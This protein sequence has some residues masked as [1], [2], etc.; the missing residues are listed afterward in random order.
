[1]M[2][3]AQAAKVL[4]GHIKGPTDARFMA[5]STDTRKIK[6]GDLYIALRGEKFDG[7]DFAAQAI[8]SGATAVLMNADSFEARSLILNPQ[9]SILLVADTRIALGQLAAHWRQKFNIP[10]VA[11]TGSNGKTTVK[12]M[13]A[14]VL[15]SAAGSDD[16]VL[17]TKGNFNN[18][19]GMPLTLLQLNAQH[20]YA[21]IE[22]G[23][24]HPGEIDYLTRIACPNVA[25]INNASG[26]HLE[27]MGSVEAV[28]HAKGEIFSGLQPGGSAIINA[29]DEFAPLWRCLAG[30]NSLLEF[31]LSGHSDVVGAWQPNGAGLRLDVKTPVGDF[32]V[33]MQ[34]PGEHNAR[35]ALAVT[36]AAIALNLSLES[37]VAG[38]SKFSGVAGRLQ[39]KPAREGAV[40]IDDTYNANPASLKAAI[41]VLAAMS[42]QRVL[43]LGDMGELGE[44][45][46]AFH[47]GIGINVRESGIENLY[48]LGELSREAVREFGVGALHFEHIDALLAELDKELKVGT[49]VLV[50]GSRF[51]K[52]ERVVKHLEIGSGKWEVVSGVGCIHSPLTT[53]D[54]PEIL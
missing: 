42:G 8:E 10:M 7:A 4:H 41:A 32:T 49:T 2:L 29:D 44:D 40:L 24:N 13:L 27:G 21:V 43:V 38:L 37:I 22:M 28:A 35:N 53:P 47:A 26:A 19:I 25:L 16:A 51:M 48:A 54:S 31:G 3:L 5:V 45:T 6:A 1:M 17:A 30:A 50:K 14:S 15:R 12:E 39:R 9:S 18:D 23:M 36:A 52:M 33:E 20:R 11:I 46:A 34:V